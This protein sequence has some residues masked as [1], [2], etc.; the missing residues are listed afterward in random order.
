[1]L[2]VYLILCEQHRRVRPM[3]ALAEQLTVVHVHSIATR[4]RTVWSFCYVK[5]SSIRD[6][7]GKGN[8]ENTAV[9]LTEGFNINQSTSS[10]DAILKA[11]AIKTN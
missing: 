11:L 10:T 7:H 8:R 4:P 5:F 1:M 6:W 2:G 9:I 3:I